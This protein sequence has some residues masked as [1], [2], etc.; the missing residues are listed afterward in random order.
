M[1]ILIAIAGLWAFWKHL[2]VNPMSEDASIDA[3][4][5]HISTPV[6]G[7]VQTFHVKDGDRV[8]QGDLLF[9]L[10]PVSYRLRVE[11]AE[12]E[13]AM[14]EALLNDRQRQIQAE[15][16][17]STIADEQIH[18]AR[19][20]LE[21]AERSLQRLLPL[22]SKGYV[23][24]QQI[25]DAMTLKRDAQ[26]S[27]NQALAQSDAAA[28]LVGNVQGAEAGVRVASSAVALAQKALSDTQV[29]APHDGLVVGLKVSTGEYVAPDQS[30]FTLINT[31]EWFATAFYRETDLPNIQLGACATVY[32]L[33]RPDLPIQ[34]KVQMIGWGVSSADMLSLPRS[35]PYVQKSL[36]WVRVAQR[37]PVRIQL[38]DP[39]PE[40]LRVGAS[41]NVVIR[42]EHNCK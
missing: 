25:D 14:A 29:Y 8:K 10:D 39:P 17:N 11:Q 33:G 23:T 30:L 7:R 2:S 37:F 15:T 22:S 32:V 24:R 20:N 18:R 41:A 19:T 4:I 9:T 3:D 5:V 31:Q 36:N 40:L 28:A 26:I 27:L 34:G 6:P 42:D 13:L 1:V 21:L 12:A 38:S 35:L 16:K